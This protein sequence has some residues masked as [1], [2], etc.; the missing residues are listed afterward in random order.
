MKT[1]TADKDLIGICGVYCGA[2]KRYSALFFVQTGRQ[3]SGLLKKKGMRL[4]HRRWRKRS[5]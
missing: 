1:L 3:L 2:C 4:L 5:R